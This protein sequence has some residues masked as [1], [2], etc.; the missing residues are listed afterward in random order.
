MQSNQPEFVRDAC[1][2]E[3]MKLR[4]YFGIAMLC[5]AFL[6]ANAAGQIPRR[7]LANLSWMA[8]CWESRDE[9]KRLFLSEQWMKPAGGVMLGIGRTVKSGKAVDFEFMRIEQQG[10][11]MFYIARPKENK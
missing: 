6:A 3:G 1:Q 7:S 4:I 9:V 2:K 10:A 11:N 8:G 5:L